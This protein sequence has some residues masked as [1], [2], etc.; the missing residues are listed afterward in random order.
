MN[1]AFFL[2]M[3]CQG[4]SRNLPTLARGS[5]LMRRFRLCQPGGESS[6]TSLP[7]SLPSS[8]SRPSLSALRASTS[9]VAATSSSTLTSPRTTS[10]SGN[11]DSYVFKHYDFYVLQGRVTKITKGVFEWS[12][13][14]EDYDEWLCGIHYGVLTTLREVTTY[15][16]V[17]GDEGQIQGRLIEEMSQQLQALEEELA[18]VNRLLLWVRQR[19]PP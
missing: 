18:Q 5:S 1:R 16:P 10:S 17:D 14:V 7:S 6:S 13:T 4:I 2:M 12:G 3:L 11:H 19:K 8:T 15:M 9:Q